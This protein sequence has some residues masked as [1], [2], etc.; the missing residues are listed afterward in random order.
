MLKMEETYKPITDKAKEF[1]DFFIV[2]YKEIYDKQ[3]YP[4]QFDF[5]R[6][7]LATRTHL[8]YITELGE[9]QL[10]TPLGVIKIS[11][12]KLSSRKDIERFNKRLIERFGL[13][14]IRPY[15]EYYNRYINGS[16]PLAN[17]M[18]CVP[19]DSQP[20]LNLPPVLN[21]NNRDAYQPRLDS[22]FRISDRTLS[23]EYFRIKTG[24]DSPW[25][26]DMT[27]EELNNAVEIREEYARWKD[28]MFG[29]NDEIPPGRKAMEILCAMVGIKPRL[30]TD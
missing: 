14:E 27:E 5:D 8:V 26:L 18:Y 24:R 13:V 22:M 3:I 25:L 12:R 29:I 4:S 6:D 16:T 30:Y 7:I 19:I 21:E 15:F 23:T 28:E 10:C 17:V 2:K 20:S 11:T 1:I 9:V